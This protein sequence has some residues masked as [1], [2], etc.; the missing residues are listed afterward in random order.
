MSTGVIEGIEDA[1]GWT[2]AATALFMNVYNW[3]S[4]ENIN[5]VVVFF[6]SVFAAFFMYYKFKN[7][8]MKHQSLKKEKND[9]QE[10]D[11]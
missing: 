8:R 3:V 1:G 10:N 9:Q 5:G 6:T 4:V 11:E 7:E 2:A